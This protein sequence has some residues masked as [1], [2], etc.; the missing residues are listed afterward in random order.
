M[1]L[2][3]EAQ[4]QLFD[5]ITMLSALRS[6]LATEYHPDVL[7]EVSRRMASD[8]RWR[9][10]GFDIDTAGCVYSGVRH[11]VRNYLAAQGW[12]VAEQT[13]ASLFEEYGLSTPDDDEP[14]R[15][16]VAV[17]AHLDCLGDVR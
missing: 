7:A 10:N 13:R 2:P 11:S 9:V 8:V 6:R 14:M 16:V 12:S 15:N 17:T 4:D 3:S 5:N 1:Y